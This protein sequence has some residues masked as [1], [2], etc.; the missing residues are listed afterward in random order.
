MYEKNVAIKR[1]KD[2]ATI[3]FAMYWNG[4]EIEGNEDLMIVHNMLNNGDAKC[5][6]LFDR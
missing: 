4:K 1:E 2:R 3:D 6:V 5:R